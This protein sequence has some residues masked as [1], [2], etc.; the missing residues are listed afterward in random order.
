MSV[1]DLFFCEGLDDDPESLR[2][3]IGNLIAVAD[4]ALLLKYYRLLLLLQEK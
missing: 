2:G 4:P 3:K 1:A